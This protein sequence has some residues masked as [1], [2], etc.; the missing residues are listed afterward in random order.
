MHSTK[1]YRIDELCECTEANTTN[2][3]EISNTL[4][5]LT[6]SYANVIKSDFYCSKAI[7][8][9]AVGDMTVEKYFV[10]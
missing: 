7:I 1:D 10:A 9:F 6:K 3:N 8:L 4:S 5:E 2:N